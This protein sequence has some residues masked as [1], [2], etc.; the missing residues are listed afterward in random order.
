MKLL[1]A[2]DFGNSIAQ[3]ASTRFD[4]T[5]I[6][7]INRAVDNVRA[8][9]PELLSTLNEAE[10]SERAASFCRLNI[11][12]E[13]SASVA[14]DIFAAEGWIEFALISL[15]DNG[16]LVPVLFTPES[17]RDLNTLRKDV[18]I[19]G[20]R[21]REQQPAKSVIEVAPAG[22]TEADLDASV[23][24]D[25]R[26]LPTSEVKSKCRDT[27]YKARLDRLMAEGRI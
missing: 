1:S 18:L 27:A 8:A 9:Y 6:N 19:R 17:L 26:T 3:A 7:V 16:V 22:P 20:F 13:S 5:P 15:L 23:I 4:R 12:V 25:W 14:S 11:P 2:E 10:W 21:V 24:S